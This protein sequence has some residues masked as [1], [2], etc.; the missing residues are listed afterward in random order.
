MNNDDKDNINNNDNKSNGNNSDNVK[1]ND[2][3]NCRRQHQMAF[4]NFS[5]VWKID[6]Q[7]DRE[8]DGRIFFKMRDRNIKI[9][10]NLGQMNMRMKSKL[11]LSDSFKTALA[12]SSTDVLLTYENWMK[13]FSCVTNAILRDYSFERQYKW[14][15][16]V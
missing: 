4:G 1:N 12:I 5:W 16:N 3:D 7:M 13:I 10:E 8:T 15:L 11:D 9:W 2:N 6:G 14:Y